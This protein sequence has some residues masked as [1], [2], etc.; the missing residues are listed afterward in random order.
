MK[1]QWFFDES[2]VLT[3]CEPKLDN[4]TKLEFA[5]ESGE[6]FYRAKLS[7]AL[8]FQNEFDA[9]LAKNFGY[10][11]IVVLKRYSDT[12][13]D[14]V[15]V[16]RGKFTLTD[17][18]I[19]YDRKT[20][21]VTPKTIDR[22]TDV[23]AALETD[24][25]IVKLK[26]QMRA[27]NFLI[28]PCVQLYALNGDKI[29]NYIGGNY[30]ETT[31]NVSN[32]R[33]CFDNDSLMPKGPEQL[34]VLIK[35]RSGYLAGKTV[36]YTGDIMGPT[37]PPLKGKVYSG[38]DWVEDY[39]DVSHVTYDEANN[40]Q[41]IEL[42]KNNVH[43]C[44]IVFEWYGAGLP[45]I[46]TWV[47]P[48]GNVEE[49]TGDLTM[50]YGRTKV[51]SDLENSVTINGNAYWLGE[52]P[53]QD[54][55]AKTYNYNKAM[56]A[57]TISLLFSDETTEEQTEWGRAY[58]G[59]YFVK[60]TDT[61]T[62]HYIPVNQSAWKYQSCW[63]YYSPDYYGTTY[64]DIERVLDK[65]Q[66]INDCYDIRY[67]ILKLLQKAGWTGQYVIS[68]VFGTRDYVGANLLPIITPKSNVISSYYDTPAQNA[69]ISLSKIFRML[70]QA[71]KVYW[72]IDENNNLH[73]EHISYF[74]NGYSYTELPQTLV[75]LE[76]D[77]HTR[78]RHSKAYGQNVVKFDKS[79]MAAVIA[80]GWMDKQTVP[81]DG[82]DIKALDSYVEQGA[83][84]ENT[85]ADFSTDVDFVLS[86]PNDV[87]KDGFFLFAL[88]NVAPG[89]YSNTLKIEKINITDE[90]GDN[91]DVT[92]QN[93]DAAFC[94]IH[95]T[96]WRYDMPCENLQINNVADTALTTGRFK[97]QSLD[98]SDLA[99]ADVISNVDN[100][101]KLI[102]TQ[103][104][105]GAIAKLSINLNSLATTA[106]LVFTLFGRK[107]YLKGAA[108]NGPMTITLNGEQITITVSNNRFVYGYTEPI[109][110]LKFAGTDVVSVD[111][112]DTDTMAELTSADDMFKNCVEL[113]AVNFANKA[114]GAVTSANNMF[115]GCVAL[116]T[117]IC[118]D[119]STWKADLDFSDC[120]ALTLES[121]YDLIKFLYYYNAGV[122]TITPNTVMWNAL[123]AT[124][125][126]DL[127]AKATAKGWTI[128][129]PAAYSITG[130]SAASTV[131][132]TINGSS[133]EIPVTAG[134]WHYDYNGA[135]TSFSFANDADLT[136]IDFSLS[137]GLAGVTSLNDAFKNCVGLTTVDF[138]NCDL[139]NVASASDA[140]ANCSALYE[141][142]I[143][144]D[145][146]RPDI[147]LS[148]SVMPKTEMLNVINGLYTY[149]SGT[150]TITFNS[151]I[152][153][154][155]IV[156]DQQI[157]F[158]AA[159]AKGWTANAV[160]VVYV[161]RGTSTNV[162]GTET[163]NIQ[164]IQDGAVNPD[165]AET[166][167][168]AVDANGDWEYEYYGKKIYSL[169][170]FCGTDGNLTNNTIASITFANAD[171]LLR[172]VSIRC[173]AART[174]ADITF[175]QTLENV[176]T[177]GDD[178]DGGAFM[179]ASGRVEMNNATFASL[180]N[181]GKMF[182]F[183][184]N[185]I[186]LPSATFE[187]LTTTN[188]ADRLGIF[189]ASTAQSIS[190]PSATFE[191]VT[192]AMR[193]F[194]NCT[195]LTSV[196]MPSATFE[197]LVDASGMFEG[198]SA[199]PS[200]DL[201]HTNLQAL[202]IVGDRNKNYYMFVGCNS[203]Q[204]VD[205]GAN[206]FP[207]LKQAVAWFANCASLTSVT[208]GA[209]TFSQLITFDFAFAGCT[210][211]VNA[212][213]FSAATFENVQDLRGTFRAT[214]IVTLNMPLATFASVTNIV[215]GQVYS[216]QHG[217]FYNCEQL[218][219]INMP[220]ATFASVLY[221]RNMFYNNNALTTLNVPSSS[222]MPSTSS[223]ATERNTDFRYSPLTYA[224]M[225]NVANWLADFTGYTAPTCIFKTSAWNALSAAEQATIQGILSGKN[226]N[227]ATA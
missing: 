2:G 95:K 7:G 21:E 36:L 111:F 154:A 60:P 151:T 107:Y 28:R 74:Q 200:V 93:G 39:I 73:L 160:A 57:A 193:M 197:R 138:T 81:F 49:L 46:E 67:T 199:L 196:S 42:S 126:N 102:K 6:M 12:D 96:F 116:T 31:A 53:L 213:N 208:W 225:L 153:D 64:A 180:T 203:L 146:W 89:V 54:I 176:V 220:S 33:D 13:N 217:L 121:F 171:D 122:H 51:N 150:H 195:S 139:S 69:P 142:I 119:S 84:E 183:Y 59:R 19:N 50:F 52:I 55:E 15:E 108:L 173:L 174:T 80:F 27:V 131:Y 169:D 134:S 168:C 179:Q 207:S 149:T 141:L 62:R 158:D 152:W 66:T 182:R 16:W 106:D 104:G 129:I 219:T 75:D 221:K 144:A 29:S 99:M 25:N 45:P 61:P 136:D 26:A 120:P 34:A 44:D 130:Q 91:Y 170:N 205:F 133:V 181:A 156:A 92:I 162:N 175:T 3:E 98:F 40:Y 41:R 38:N 76:S 187:S 101:I 191:N 135:V 201:S 68:G 192:T 48:N 82:Y 159:D 63:Y 85:I 186:S 143:P 147:D 194:Y 185:N 178:N 8:T 125:Q 164:F 70:K 9:I 87:S 17:C 172:C 78:T 128:N 20:I 23:I 1:Y 71:Y 65:P 224:S 90:N 58:D 32:F 77:L 218:A 113:I 118:P 100:C 204:S 18:T 5:P 227:L 166:I 86:S 215:S 11:H 79:G 127:I 214:K 123:D 4:E 165:A 43:E 10:T 222:S 210:S 206:T 109:N 56:R 140:F 47:N 103:Q 209:P 132:A 190:L 37:I 110:E 112:A 189:S 148:A 117:L 155:M 216:D 30:W 211:L 167:T 161:I 177:A 124:V 114:F 94:K 212:P 137:D 83:K 14:Y 145:S 35:W 24:Y 72:Y 105:F 97:T 226:W 223:S 115:R 184:T 88:P 157:V 202:E 163:F 198:C 188:S 22:Y